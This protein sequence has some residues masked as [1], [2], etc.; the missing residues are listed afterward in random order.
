MNN[1]SIN[2]NIENN[3]L[4][5]LSVGCWGVYC[6]QGEYLIFKDKK[7]EI[8]QENVL[9]GQ[10]IVAESL[11]LYTK[12]YPNIKDMFL[13][14]DNVYQV[15][16]EKNNENTFQYNTDDLE[17]FLSEN[18]GLQIKDKN[19]VFN[20]EKQISEGFEKCFEKVNI[21]RYFVA[22]GNH[23]IET[24]EILNTELKNDS[25]NMP[26]TYYNVVYNTANNISVN[27]IVID[28]NMFEEVP[29]K[30]DKSQYTE[31]E[32]KQQI[33]WIKSVS[34][35]GSWKIV[36]G[37]VPYIA[38]GHKKKKPVIFNNSLSQIFDIVKPQVYLCADEHNQQ[39]LYNNDKF[40]SLIVCGSG[41]T[42]L[43]SQIF[44]SRL[45]ENT[46]TLYKNPVFGFVHLSFKDEGLLIKYINSTNQQI[47]FEVLIN[48]NGNILN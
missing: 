27:C 5:L 8:E 2:I 18:F 9:R 24:C 20:I 37:H 45:P 26:N 31:D 25:W 3:I 7:G 41:G 14:G 36:I 23:D 47:T 15:G 30:C 10:R 13:A 17:K 42:A 12:K 44:N 35:I 48:K 21:K 6:N 22:V 43:D 33:D 19:S 38:N 32:I 28:T 11:E 39:F 16:I 29:L 46:Y 34:N 1:L 4:D 40:L